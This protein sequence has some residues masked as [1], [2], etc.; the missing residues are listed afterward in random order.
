[1]LSLLLP[2]LV[3]VGGAVRQQM[4]VME[5]EGDKTAPFLVVVGF[6][7]FLTMNAA[8]PWIREQNKGRSVQ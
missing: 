4:M 1:V 6:V 8:V 7:Y 3:F 5:G 2:L